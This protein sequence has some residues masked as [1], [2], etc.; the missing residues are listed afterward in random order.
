[1]SLG[2]Y[3][4]PEGLGPRIPPQDRIL[5]YSL[6]LNPG[7]KWEQALPPLVHGLLVLQKS[8]TGPFGEE[9]SGEEP[10]GPEPLGEER[11]FNLLAIKL[12]CPLRSK[13]FRESTINPTPVKL[14]R[15]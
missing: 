5:G 7:T 3:S 2:I 11:P 1:V 8:P 6:S 14:L 12:S 4:H 15:V 10:L 9:P 13:H